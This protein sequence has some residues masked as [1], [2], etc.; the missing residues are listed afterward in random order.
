MTPVYVH[1]SLLD[2]H[3]TG[4]KMKSIPFVDFGKK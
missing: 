3:L 4:E 2:E 1:I